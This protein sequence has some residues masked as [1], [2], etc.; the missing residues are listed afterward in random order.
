MPAFYRPLPPAHVLWQAFDY[1]PLTG[2]LI[3]KEPPARKQRLKGKRVGS[4][5]RG[6]L[7]CNW[8]TGL[9]NGP[10]PVHRLIYCWV[11]GKDPGS[12]QIDHAN[13]VKTDN[14]F[15]NLRLADQTMQNANKRQRKDSQTQYKGV[16]VIKQGGRTYIA[17]RCN[18]KHLG[19]FSS[20]EEA[21]EAYCKA[22][23]ITFN[24]YWR[25]A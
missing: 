5:D 15:Q 2:E 20:Q 22:A 9:G 6:Y 12:L 1:K 25:A 10:V 23:K 19:M 3:W 13:M 11:T 8:R 21:H 24:K 14:R 7:V 18:G 17:A 4:V 16:T